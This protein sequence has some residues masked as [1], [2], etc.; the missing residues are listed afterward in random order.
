M[1]MII[2]ESFQRGFHP[3]WS[4]A[5]TGVV[6]TLGKKPYL[7]TGSAGR[8]LRE[9]CALKRQRGVSRVLWFRT[10]A[11]TG[12][13]D[14]ETRELWHRSK[15][16]LLGGG[17]PE[18]GGVYYSPQTTS[19][20]LQENIVVFKAARNKQGK[21]GFGSRTVVWPHSSACVGQQVGN[22]HSVHT[23]TPDYGN[24][25]PSTGPG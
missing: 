8:P 22:T 23:V 13:W 15:T 10:L 18:A 6:W 7:W 3:V 25:P 9:V 12:S 16:N 14:G 19:Q 2:I 4:R 17:R 1:C 21:L 24:P 5:P 20:R 11:F